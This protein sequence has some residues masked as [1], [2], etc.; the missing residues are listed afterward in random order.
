MF[1]WG[2]RK[3]RKRSCGVHIP[4]P[5]AQIK[6][7]KCGANRLYRQN[8][9]MTRAKRAEFGDQSKAIRGSAAMDLPTT[10][11]GCTMWT[12]DA[13]LV[14][15]RRTARLMIDPRLRHPNIEV[16]RHGQSL[17]TFA[18]LIFHCRGVADDASCQVHI[19]CFGFQF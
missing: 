15:L 2:W 4:R 3:R 13:R 11:R 14:E 7:S 9:E 17:C 16:Q 6:W 5:R 12:S 1:G 18:H 8:L 10:S 19:A